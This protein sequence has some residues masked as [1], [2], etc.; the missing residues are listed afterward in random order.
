MRYSSEAEV[1]EVLQQ[2][3]PNPR[4]VSAGAS[5]APH[6]LLDVVD[7]V[8]PTYRLNM[9]NAKR[10]IPVRE[11]VTHETVFVGPGMRNLPSLVYTPCRLSLVPALFRTT[12]APDIVLL[13]VAPPRDGKVSMGIE[14]MTLV[15]AMEAVKARGGL[16]LGQVNPAMPYTFGDGLVDVED[17]DALFE[18]ETPLAIPSGTG[19][20][21]PE[22][23]TIGQLTSGRVPD[24]ATLQLGIGVIPNATLPGL[25][26]RRNLGLWT[27]MMSDGVLALQR[28]GALDSRR[29]VV[30]SFALGNEE[31][32]EWMHLNPHLQMRRTEVTNDPA[33]IARQPRMTA[34][35]SALQVDLMAQANASRIGARIYSG[36]GGQTDFIVGALHSPGGQALMALQSI[37]AKKK[38][39]TIVP[40]LQEPVT[41]FQASAIITEQGVATVFGNNE[42]DQARHIIDCAAHPSVRPSLW[43]AA[44]RL[45]LA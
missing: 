14:V 24:G 1:K 37:H 30:C 43:Q 23:E 6:A 28:A 32:Y 33:M 21:D 19:A 27:E 13:H 2:A 15:A 38:V 9:I 39:S 7:R 20:L 5:I 31:F 4:I 12:L 41:S 44:A 8:L 18:G 40:L 11:G 22:V 16:L 25:G 29:D 35:N 36:F 45:G 3:P 10:G 26:R 17:F 34:I 42:R